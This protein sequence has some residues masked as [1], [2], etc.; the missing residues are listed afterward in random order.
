MWAHIVTIGLGGWLLAEPDVVGY[1]GPPRIN[2]EIVGA[3]I[4]TFG[5][6]A[7]SE[8]VRAVR[9]VNMGLGS[10][11]VCAPFILRY[12][13]ERTWTSLAIGLAVSLLAWAGGN[14]SERFGGGWAVLWRSSD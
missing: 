8:S 5:M 11:L 13:A 6:I 1:S 2:H 9:W 4:I 3:W 12:P 10:W 7:L 14:L